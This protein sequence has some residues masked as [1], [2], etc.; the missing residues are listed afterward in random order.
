MGHSIHLLLLH[1]PPFGI[2]GYMVATT[3]SD[4]CLSYSRTCCSPCL[5]ERSFEPGELVNARVAD[6]Q[7]VA[8]LV[9]AGF[10]MMI[11]TAANQLPAGQAGHLVSPLRTGSTKTECVSFWYYMGG[12]NPG[13]TPG[14][15]AH[16]T[17]TTP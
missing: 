5:V 3:T 15:P 11:N 14:L 7:V 16:H 9:P 1:Y 8:S 6:S 12:M 17:L 10:Y 4:F 13:E 2:I